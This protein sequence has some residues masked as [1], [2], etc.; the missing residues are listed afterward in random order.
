[1]FFAAFFFFVS[2]SLSL[3]RCGFCVKSQKILTGLKIKRKNSKFS[4]AP[5]KTAIHIKHII[6]QLKIYFR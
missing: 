3:K 6:T 1:M 5:N 4:Q 2:F